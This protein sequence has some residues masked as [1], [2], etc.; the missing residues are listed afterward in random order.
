MAKLRTTLRVAAMPPG[1]HEALEAA[2]RSNAAYLYGLVPAARLT[3]V[4]DSGH[5]I[6]AEKPAVVIE[7]IHQVVAGV[8]D[9]DTWYD[10]VSCCTP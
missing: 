1:Y 7:A 8:R 3:I 10:L 5:Y 4:P 2:L 6:Q 9:P